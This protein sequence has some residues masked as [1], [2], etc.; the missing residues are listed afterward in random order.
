[1]SNLIELKDNIFEEKNN[2]NSNIFVD[3][4]I[5]V[6]Q[7]LINFDFNKYSI[8][9]FKKLDELNKSNIRLFIRNSLKK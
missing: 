1:M 4:F 8:K 7:K 5:T 3:L 2:T 6:D 9:S